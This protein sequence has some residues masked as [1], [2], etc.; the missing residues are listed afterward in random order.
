[1]ADIFENVGAMSTI[2]APARQ[3]LVVAPSDSTPFTNAC[4][5]LYV[6]GSG[7]VNAIC[8]GDSTP[9]LFTNVSGVLPVRVKQVYATSTTATSIVA[10]Y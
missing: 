2:D 6:G 3:A 10:L 8:S 7:D 4:R 9:T 1:M 5:A